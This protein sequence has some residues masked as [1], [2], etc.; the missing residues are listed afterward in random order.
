MQKYSDQKETQK[1]LTKHSSMR[2]FLSSSTVSPKAGY[3]TAYLLK[4]SFNCT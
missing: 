3:L 2:N 1:A 4:S